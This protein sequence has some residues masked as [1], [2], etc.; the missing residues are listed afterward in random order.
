[1]GPKQQMCLKLSN[2]GIRILHVTLYQRQW[3]K[4]HFA[5][6][7]F[8]PANGPMAIHVNGVS[9]QREYGNNWVKQY[10]GMIS[11]IINSLWPSDAIWWHRS[12]SAPAQV[13]ACCL[14]APTH[15][16]NQ[17]RHHQRCSVV[18]VRAISQVVMNLICTI[19]LE[20]ALLK[21]QPHLLGDNELTHWGLVTPY[22][23]GDLGQHWFR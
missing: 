17:C 18:F 6:K 11:F 5:D 7:V 19:C 15:Y 10:F 12:G 3:L 8:I 14:M 23:P 1:M 16:L 13:M 2:N 4:F 21:S 22:G 9:Y 20:I